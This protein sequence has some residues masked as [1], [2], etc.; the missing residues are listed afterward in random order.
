M[1]KDMGKDSVKPKGK[2]CYNPGL[3]IM[4]ELLPSHSQKVREESSYGNSGKET[5]PDSIDEKKH[6]QPEVS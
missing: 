5:Q 4:E 2:R 3:V 1:Y 6:S